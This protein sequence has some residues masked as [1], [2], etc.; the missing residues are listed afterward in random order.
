MQGRVPAGARGFVTQQTFGEQR[1]RVALDSSLAPG[2]RDQL[3]GLLGRL[4]LIELR[5]DDPDYRIV[6]PA[7]SSRGGRETL[8][9]IGAA[10]DTLSRLSGPADTLVV[11]LAAR[12]RSVARSRYYRGIHLQDPHG[13]L[14]LAFELILA[15]RPIRR[16]REGIEC[17]APADTLPQGARRGPGGALTLNPDDA[18]WIRVRNLG[19][20][21]AH[22]AILDLMADHS[23]TLLFPEAGQAVSDAV[24]G[25]GRSYKIPTCFYATEP[26]GTEVLKLVATTR[27]VDWSPVLTPGLTN[28]SGPLTPLQRLF[29]DTESGTRTG[30]LPVGQAATAEL[31][32]LVAPRRR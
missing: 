2:I 25:P 8:F 29:A 26:F 28:R 30:G 3:T 24:V 19:K 5:T 31:S 18:Y 16:T 27:A 15:R 11:T 13:Q 22:F 20:Q 32:V 4:S 14:R 17:P 23:V 1:Y 6:S 21:P 9:L 10:G 12:L 7:R